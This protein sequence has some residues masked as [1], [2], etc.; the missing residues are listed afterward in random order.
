MGLF[1][2][3]WSIPQPMPVWTDAHSESKR[4]AETVSP[5]ADVSLMK[6]GC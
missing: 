1:R 5:T 6:P 2:T 4:F 3:S